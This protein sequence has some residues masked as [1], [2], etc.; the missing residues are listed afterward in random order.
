[1]AAPTAT[2]L[3]RREIRKVLQRH[4]GEMIRLAQ[5]LSVNR[6]TVSNVLAGRMTSARILNAAEARAHELLELETQE[7]RSRR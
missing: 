5:A 7:A 4:R 3:R 1:M 2:P 6:I